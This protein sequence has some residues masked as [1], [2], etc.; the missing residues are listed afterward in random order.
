VKLDP[1]RIQ[2]KVKKIIFTYDS[3]HSILFSNFSLPC[4]PESL[5]FEK[6]GDP[7][8]L[9]LP[10]SI[11]DQ[12][13]EELNKEEA[14]E[15][16]ENE[17]RF[18]Q[19]KR[20]ME[21]FKTK[22]KKFRHKSDIVDK[23]KQNN[24]LIKKTFEMIDQR[25]SRKFIAQILDIKK[26]TID[27]LCDK[28]KKKGTYFLSKIG[29]PTKIQQKFL[30]FIE[31]YLSHQLHQFES[32]YAVR[33]AIC[34]HFKV[35][36]NYFSLMT[37]AKMIKKCGFRRKRVKNTIYR[38]NSEQTIQKRMDLAKAY[39]NWIKQDK[40]IIYIDES[41]FSLG[42]QPLYGYQKK[43][44]PLKLICPAR[45]KKISV[46]AAIKKD[47]VLG[48]QMI[49]GNV[50]SKTY[51]AFFLNLIKNN[52]NIKTNLKNVV[53]FMDN[54]SIHKGAILLELFSVCKIQYNAPYSPFLN[55][56]EEFFGLW[57]WYTRQKKSKTKLDLMKNMLDS[58]PLISKSNLFGFYYHSIKFIKNSLNK[59]EIE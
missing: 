45:Q 40:I 52:P 38:R 44:L 39:M 21:K 54:A 1:N 3:P 5:K 26:S 17:I 14:M 19:N 7:Q 8:S 48:I 22:K 29:R 59:E 31:I 2:K 41:A 51:G 43:N 53:F 55:P 25:Y 27:Y 16:N 24:V 42:L 50:T 37:I 12:P 6:N 56:I 15:I 11:Y 28:R 13:E 10:Y 33:R 58:I 47:T 23:L 34:N 49:E 4:N 36:T 18:C 30:D 57:K 46:I 35:E 9:D 32:R 20:E